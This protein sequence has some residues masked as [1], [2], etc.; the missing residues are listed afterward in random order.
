MAAAAEARH[1]H[2]QQQHQPQLTQLLSSGRAQAMETFMSANELQTGRHSLYLHHMYRS[3]TPRE[4]SPVGKH[5]YIHQV[6]GD[7]DGCIYSYKG[8]VLVKR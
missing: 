3:R 7:K 5:R 6:G 2:E 4:R 1:R 8:L